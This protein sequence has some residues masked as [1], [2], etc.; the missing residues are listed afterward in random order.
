MAETGIYLTLLGQL[1]VNYAKSPRISARASLVQFTY[2]AGDEIRTRD[3]LLGSCNQPCPRYSLLVT[4]RTRVEI[5][6]CPHQSSMV[7]DTAGVNK[8]SNAIQSLP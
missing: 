3:I 1:R 8:V 2:G 5:R 7:S 6:Y 4:A